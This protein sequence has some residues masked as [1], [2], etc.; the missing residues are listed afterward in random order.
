MTTISDRIAQFEHMAA[1]DPSN[2][3]AHFSLGSAYL[4]AGRPDDAARCFQRCIELN[5]EM[6]KA[7]QLAGQALIDAGREEE[8]A[9]VLRAGYAVAS[10]KGDMMPR[11]T[12]EGLLQGL[13]IE[14]PPA[15]DEDA[16]AGAAERGAFVCHLT[17]RPGTRLPAPPMRGRLGQWVY[18]NISAETWQ[19]WIAQGTKVINELRLDFSRDED[20]QT[21]DRYMCEYLGIDEALFRKLMG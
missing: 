16:P 17:G 20:Q 15:A 10:R 3:M 8:A 13:G 11:R 5:A 12:I 18:D 1:E 21:Y 19:A 14:P 4:Q 2:D 7:Y 9:D 6:S